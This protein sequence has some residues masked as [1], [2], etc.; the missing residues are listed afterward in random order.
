[1]KWNGRFFVFLTLVF[2]ALLMINTTAMAAKDAVK[3]DLVDKQ[4]AKANAAFDAGKMGDMSGYDPA[5][6]ISPTGDTIKIAIVASF[7]G[8]SADQRA[9]LLEHGHLGCA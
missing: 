8:P 5:T 3:G 6:W 2:A 9:I 1:M 7:S 4:L